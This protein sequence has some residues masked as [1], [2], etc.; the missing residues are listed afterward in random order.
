MENDTADAAPLRIAIY[1]SLATEMQRP[2]SIECQR[3]RCS[4]VAQNKGWTVDM[5]YLVSDLYIRGQ[6]N[7]RH[8][9]LNWLCNCASDAHHPFDGVVVDDPF[10]LGDHLAD[11]MRAIKHLL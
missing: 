7:T 9:G 8:H 11:I 5:D 1:S 10:R 4:E 6:A 3:C 2:A